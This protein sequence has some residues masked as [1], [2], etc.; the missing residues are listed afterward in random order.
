MKR[1]VIISIALIVISFIIAISLYNSMP[2]KMISHWN[3]KGEA[4]GF[5]PKF[6]ALFLFPIILTV[7]LIL[8]YFIPLIDPLKKNIQ[9]FQE[10][11]HGLILAI[12]LLLFY[13]FSLSILLNVNFV[14]NITFML[15][16]AFAIFFFYLGIVIEKSKMN[17]FVGIRTPWTL[18]DERVWNATHYLGGKLFKI[19]AGI[20]LIGIFFG[21]YS[22]FFVLIPII[23]SGVFL[24]VYSY[25]KYREIKKK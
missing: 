1:G 2:E 23:L 6:W 7:I 9:K 11:Y 5:L 16:P 10:Y 24:I 14:F 21:E 17:W 3:Y 4:D 18:S 13:V 25:F 20:S 8:F 19:S 22:M 15:I 12:T